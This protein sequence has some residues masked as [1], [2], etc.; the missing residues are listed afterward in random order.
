MANFD[1]TNQAKLSSVQN[2]SQFL[3]RV[4]ALY[5]HAREMQTLLAL[6]Q[7]NSDPVFNAAINAMFTASERNELAAMLTQVNALVTDWDANH[8]WVKA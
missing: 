5:I 4:K 6:Y 8:A 1:N 7:S 2:A 3:D